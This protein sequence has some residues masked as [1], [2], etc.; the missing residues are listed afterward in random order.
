MQESGNNLT[1]L[2]SLLRLRASMVGGVLA[3]IK[4]I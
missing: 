2:V 1:A 3:D 4:Y